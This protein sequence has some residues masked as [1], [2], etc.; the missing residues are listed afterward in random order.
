MCLFRYTVQA[1]E[2]DPTNTKAIYRRAIAYLKIGELDR[3]H[4]DLMT[5]HNMQDLDA[6]DKSALSSAFKDLKDA[7]ERSKQRERETAEK[8]FKFPSQPVN[9]ND[10]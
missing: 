1:L 5:L 2:N 7:R 8:M 10:A 3:C 4:K 6:N 9:D